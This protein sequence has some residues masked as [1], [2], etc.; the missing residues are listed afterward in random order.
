ML[1][2]LESA[3]GGDEGLLKCPRCKG[4]YLHHMTVKVFDRGEDAKRVDVTTLGIDGLSR[5]TVPSEGSGNP[6][7]RRDGLTIE[8]WCEECGEDTAFIL[9]VS[10]HKG[11]T[12]LR[13]VGYRLLERQSSPVLSLSERV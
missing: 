11:C 4:D 10:Q 7:C 2:E 9:G 13:W 1:P 12:Y 8:F 3:W 5:R 6:S